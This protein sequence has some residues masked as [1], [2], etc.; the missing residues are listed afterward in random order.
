MGKDSKPCAFY[1]LKEV[2]KAIDE[3][4]IE[5]TN[6]HAREKNR[7]TLRELGLTSAD[8]IKH[9]R[10][11]NANHFKE[12]SCLPGRVYADVYIKKINKES[13]YIKFFL[14]NDLVV[15]SFHKDEPR[16]KK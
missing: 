11:L 5:I 13:V 10:S 7:N 16:R 3:G 4:R 14:D 12:T 15:L 9:I 2:F 6:F 8:A 1:P